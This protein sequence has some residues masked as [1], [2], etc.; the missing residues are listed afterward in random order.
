MVAVPMRSASLAP[1]PPTIHGAP[2][3]PGR[4]PRVSEK[5][6]VGPPERRAHGQAAAGEGELE[7]SAAP[8][9]EVD[10]CIHAG[11]GTGIDK[12][13]RVQALHRW[14]HEA[15]DNQSGM[16]GIDLTCPSRASP[17]PWPALR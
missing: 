5:V 11:A 6:A 12:G 10:A 4:T 13:C 3:Q 9:P 2:R 15:F 8:K 1:G 7:A 17:C 16:G 14:N